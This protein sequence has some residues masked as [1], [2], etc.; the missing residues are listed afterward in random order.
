MYILSFLQCTNYTVVCD[1]IDSQQI[2]SS[3]KR[4]HFG[5]ISRKTVFAICKSGRRLTGGRGDK[6][7]FGGYKN[8][9]TFNP[10]VWAKKQRPSLRN[11][12]KSMVKIKK[13]RS[14]S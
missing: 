10:R 14:P 1:Q 5:G 7:N 4:Q 13:K 9:N 3:T 2:I 6:S 11:S 8:F 12:T